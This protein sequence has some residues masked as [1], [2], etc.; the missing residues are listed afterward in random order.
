MT[1]SRA[2]MTAPRG[3][4]LTRVSTVKQ[5]QEGRSLDGQY[6]DSLAFA[7][8]LGIPIVASFR[9]AWTGREAS[10][11]GL[12]T[13]LEMLNRGEANCLFVWNATRFARKAS[14]G[15]SLC[16]D[17]IEAG[18]RL[19]FSKGREEYTG[20]KTQKF[21]YGIEFLL[22]E[23]DADNINEQ[24]RIGR[25]RKIKGTSGTE[26]QV[27]GAGDPPYGYNWEGYGK[28]RRLAVNPDQAPW[29][30]QIFQWYADGVPVHRSKSGADSIVRRLAH[31]GAP[32]PDKFQ[33]G[34]NPGKPLKRDLGEFSPAT[35]YKMLRRRAYVGQ[36]EQD[37]WRT[38]RVKGEKTATGRAKW[39]T[40][41]R[42]DSEVVL[43]PCPSILDTPELVQLFEQ[44]QVQLSNGRKNSSRNIKYEYL[45]AKRLRCAHCGCVYSG[46]RGG[47]TEKDRREGR[48]RK[49][50]KDG[51]YTRMYYRC[52]GTDKHCSTQNCT[53]PF[54]K[55]WQVDEA[56]WTWI[57]TRLTNAAWVGQ[58]LRAERADSYDAQGELRR[59]IGW[60]EK[61]IDQTTDTIR[62][63][64]MQA[65]RNARLA[66]ILEKD[67]DQQSDL[68]GRLERDLADAQRLVKE[69]LS[70][71]QIDSI[72]QAC[73][74]LAATVEAGWTFDERRE[75][76]EAIKM[77]ALVRRTPTGEIV[78]DL[79]S[80][81]KVSE[82]GWKLHPDCVQIEN[83]VGARLI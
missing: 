31:Y 13:A 32:L 26:P 67:I 62:G 19:F 5:E 68:L 45:M 15:M 76:V 29:V 82:T 6:D 83:T 23:T 4:I 46:L 61:E 1:A 39:K 27:Y 74:A 17:L 37:R 12:E 16:E 3:I 64:G 56:V 54:I 77:T 49:V 60:L 57:T 71:Q 65:A 22:G 9:D 35:I 7:E 80:R 79:T 53:M 58:L 81:F 2:A 25:E 18:Y 11:S 72:S 75:L 33:V 20:E 73:A 36:F 40:T 59:K 30:V 41:R 38:T 69:Q 43:V 21:R 44:V 47:Q 34:K 28:A 78:L 52:L 10:R 63:L 42:D 66:P 50:G 14:D 55:Y 8:Q 48:A 70:D 51:F 24:L